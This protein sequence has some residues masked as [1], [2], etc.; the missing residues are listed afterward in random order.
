MAGLPTYFGNPA[1]DHADRFMDLTGIGKLMALSRRAD[2]NDLLCTHF[3]AEFGRDSVFAL[4]VTLDENEERAQKY[5]VAAWRRGRRPF[6]EDMSLAKFASLLAKGSEIRVTGISEEFPYAAYLEK[7]QGK[8]VPLLAWNEKNR[9]RVFAAGEDWSP[10]AGW[11]I[12]SL[13][14]AA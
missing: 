9:L 11:K 6:A 7:Y 1:S 2:F 14:P 8:A 5:A 12:A 10:G 4:P 13:H 3:A